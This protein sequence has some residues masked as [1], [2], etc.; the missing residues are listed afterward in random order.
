MVSQ[1]DVVRVGCRCVVCGSPSGEV[2]VDRSPLYRW[3]FDGGSV[4][5]ALPDSS[6]RDHGIVLGRFDAAGWVCEGCSCSTLDAMDS[7][8]Q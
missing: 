8:D 5:L 3:L 7:L 4:E 2:A 1:I 6:E